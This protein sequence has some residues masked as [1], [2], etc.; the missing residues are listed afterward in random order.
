MYM[1][2]CVDC[3]GVQ[4]R[5]EEDESHR[6]ADQ[7]RENTW[8][9][10]EGTERLEMLCHNPEHSLLLYLKEQFIEKCHFFMSFQTVWLC[11]S[12]EHKRR[13]MADC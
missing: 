8:I 7:H 13:C 9:Q 10:V 12:I 4:W 6:G 1:W 11:S 5:S 2:V 3:E